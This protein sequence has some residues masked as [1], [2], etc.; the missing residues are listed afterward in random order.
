MK[1]PYYAEITFPCASGILKNSVLIA[2]KIQPDTITKS[3][4]LM[5]FKEI[6]VVHYENNMK[7]I[8]TLYVKNAEFLSIKAGGT[9]NYHL[10][11]KG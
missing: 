6:I 11:L 9:D 8:N 7:P 4:W 10:T 5:R 1:V 2:K 3:S